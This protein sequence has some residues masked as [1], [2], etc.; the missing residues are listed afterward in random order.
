MSVK[1]S[2][3]PRGS[4]AE[5]TSLDLGMDPPQGTCASCDQS[6]RR[7]AGVEVRRRYRFGICLI[8]LHRACRDA[9]G[10]EGIARVVADREAHWA[11]RLGIPGENR[12]TSPLADTE[13]EPALPNDPHVQRHVESG[14]HKCGRTRSSVVIQ[15]CM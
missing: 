12:Q 10:E 4:R 2:D 7:G 6:V 11:Q 1:K 15:P 14:P 13:G 3:S 5:Q 9:I 8:T